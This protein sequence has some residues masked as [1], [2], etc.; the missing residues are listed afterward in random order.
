MQT[1]Q[2]ELMIAELDINE[3]RRDPMSNP[4]V[5][6]H[7]GSCGTIMKGKKWNS[8]ERLWLLSW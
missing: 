6:M 7:G 8:R 1:K 2:M 3:I 4:C 5:R